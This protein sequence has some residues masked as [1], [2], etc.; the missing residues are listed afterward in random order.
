M[1][2]AKTETIPDIRTFERVLRL[3]LNI[4]VLNVTRQ[5]PPGRPKA[6]PTN[7]SRTGAALQASSYHLSGA[8]KAYFPV[9]HCQHGHVET[10]ELALPAG[11]RRG[12]SRC[13]E[14]HVAPFFALRRGCAVDHELRLVQKLVTASMFWPSNPS[15]L[16]LWFID[17][18]SCGYFLYVIS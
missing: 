13:V 18:P 12:S 1:A 5:S 15:I 14:E 8:H 4:L 16:S 9:V 2:T 17:P 10:H 3:I 6:R 11:G 7:R